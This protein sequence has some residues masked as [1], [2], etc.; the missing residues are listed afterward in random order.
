MMETEVEDERQKQG[1]GFEDWNL[2]KELGILLSLAKEGDE[3]RESEMEGRK[4]I[5][6][7]GI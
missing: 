7:G 2:N 3:E 5:P 6:F 4:G 1:E